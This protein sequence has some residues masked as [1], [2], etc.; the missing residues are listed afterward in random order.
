[1]TARTRRPAGAARALLALVPLLALTACGPVDDGPGVASADGAGTTQDSG[2]TGAPGG[3]DDAAADLDDDELALEFAACMRDNGVDMPDPDTD[4]GGMAVTL[5]GDGTDPADV[6]AAFEACKEFLPNGGEPVEMSPEDLE[7][8]R[9]Y[10]QCMREHGIDM[11]DPDPD[12][13]A[14][15]MPAMPAGDEELQAAIEACDE[16]APML[17]TDE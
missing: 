7:A 15:A 10:A 14:V 2:T 16:A 17:G 5:G 3:G 11:P 1:M 12:G 4:G 6:D 9:A 13:G 8:M